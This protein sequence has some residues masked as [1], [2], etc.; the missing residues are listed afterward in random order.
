MLTLK[1]KSN[2]KICHIESAIGF[3]SFLSV[4][5][6]IRTLRQYHDIVYEQQELYAC[7]EQLALGPIYKQL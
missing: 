4:F 7:A 3:D 5:I 6:V 2:N 1:Q